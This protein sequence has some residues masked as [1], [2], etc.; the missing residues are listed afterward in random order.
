MTLQGRVQNLV[1]NYNK[2]NDSIEGK[3]KE[4][5]NIY[6]IK[7]DLKRL[8]FINDLPRVL[9]TQLSEYLGNGENNISVLEKSLKYYE[10]CKEFLFLHKENVF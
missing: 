4:T 10:K 1:G 2:I 3:L 9:E 6:M 8:K 7:K 5:Q